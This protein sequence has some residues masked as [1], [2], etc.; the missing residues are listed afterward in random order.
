[1]AIAL[2][3]ANSN[4]VRLPPPAVTF[5]DRR[6]DFLRIFN[7]KTIAAMFYLSFF[8]GVW[9]FL[10]M[11]IGETAEQTF[12]FV[13]Y[14]TRQTLVSAVSVLLAMAL[15]EAFLPR[16]LP[17]VARTALVV[18]GIAAGAFTST[19]GRI[20]LAR[21][22]TMNSAE[23]LSW[24]LFVGLIWTAIGAVAYLILSSLRD[25]DATRAALADARCDEERLS[26]QV[27]EGDAAGARASLRSN[28]APKA[29]ASGWTWPT[30]AAG[31]WPRRARASALLIPA[32]G[33][34]R[35]TAQQRASTC[36]PITPKAWSRK[37]VC[38]CD[39]PRRR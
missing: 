35:Y 19:F 12:F 34:R 20:A 30:P 31:S 32:P 28:L 5:F 24:V 10:P 16:Q 8:V 22:A 29:R 21:I 39:L 11:G 15:A 18:A 38:L 14:M 4:T 2:P 37:C 27:I 25:D 3:A 1:M 26:T 9:S 13:G 33:W 17:R 23:H 36:T 6:S 7:L